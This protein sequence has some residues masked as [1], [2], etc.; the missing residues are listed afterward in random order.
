M[1]QADTVDTARIVSSLRS[2]IQQTFSALLTST[3]IPPTRTTNQA[4]TS[5]QTRATRPSFNQPQSNPSFL[6]I[7]RCFLTRASHTYSPSLSDLRSVLSEIFAAYTFEET[8]LNLAN[9]FLDKES[10]EHVAEITELRKRGWRPR[11]QV[12]EGCKKRCWGPGA[13]GSVWEAWE[14]REETRIKARLESGGSAGRDGEASGKAKGKRPSQADVLEENE[15]EEK[16]E[17][18]VLFACRHL[19]HRGCLERA[20][21]A[22]G[23]EQSA[24]GGN[25]E[26]G[27][28]M[29]RVGLKCPLC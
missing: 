24:E 14:K 21:S 18:L 13:G 6:R 3:T 29:G 7:L 17:S 28:M 27:K 1:D 25:A 23:Q 5:T 10:F 22:V 20:G 4:R 26:V 11:G 12:C 19:W 15:G 9:R 2:T 16:E 8:I